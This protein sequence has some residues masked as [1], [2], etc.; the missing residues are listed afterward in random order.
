[1]SM[2][3]CQRGLESLEC[4]CAVKNLVQALS[5]KKNIMATDLF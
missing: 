2:A 3:E 1:M 4:M 5:N